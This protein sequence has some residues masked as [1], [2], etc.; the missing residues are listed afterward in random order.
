MKSSHK[1]IPNKSLNGLHWHTLTIKP[2]PHKDAGGRT[3]HEGHFRSE[4]TVRR[5]C[6]DVRVLFYARR[7]HTAVQKHLED[8]ECPANFHSQALD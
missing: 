3:L 7:A 5:R 1:P 2:L 8:G 4:P 6:Y